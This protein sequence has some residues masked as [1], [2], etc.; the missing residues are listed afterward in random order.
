MALV[1]V[2]EPS[3]SLA[4]QQHWSK[5]ERRG[6]LSSTSATEQKVRWAAEQKGRLGR[7]S[8][9][10]FQTNLV[11]PWLSLQCLPRSFKNTFLQAERWLKWNGTV[12]HAAGG[13]TI[14]T[15]PVFLPSQ[16]CSWSCRFALG[17]QDTILELPVLWSWAQYSLPCSV[18]PAAAGAPCP[19]LGPT[20]CT[21][22][23]SSVKNSACISNTKTKLS[24][25]F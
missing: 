16:R 23:L 24:K 11:C 6:G 20:S 18:P 1:A 12:W 25:E 10:H 13:R 21:V 7:N 17:H 5:W 14:R 4:S 9:M 22:W 15:Y 3:P 2:P 8:A 19:A